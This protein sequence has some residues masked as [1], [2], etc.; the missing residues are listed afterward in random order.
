MIKTDYYWIYYKRTPWTKYIRRYSEEQAE[1]V[2]KCE[3]MIV[4]KLVPSTLNRTEYEN[5]VSIPEFMKLINDLR[6]KTDD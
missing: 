1:H 2:R 4:E 6:R 5:Q 3:G